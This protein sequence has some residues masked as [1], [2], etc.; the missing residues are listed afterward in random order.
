[1]TLYVVLAR[2]PFAA[3][4]A[5]VRFLACVREN[6][7]RVLRHRCRSERETTRLTAQEVLR[8]HVAPQVCVPGNKDSFLQVSQS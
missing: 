1:M 3:H 5:A 4:V 7:K 8:A 6:V 2:E